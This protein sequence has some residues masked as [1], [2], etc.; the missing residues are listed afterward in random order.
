[1]SRIAGID[2]CGARWVCVTF[3]TDSRELGA[4]LLETRE[5][6]PARW[7]VAAIDVPIGLPETGPRAADHEARR[8]LRAPR[9]ASVFSCPPRAVLDS[10]TWEEMSER[11]RSI[12]GTGVSKQAFGILRKVREVDSLLRSSPEA[13]SCF[14]EAHPEVSFAAWA[15]HSMRHGKKSVA[16]KQERRELIDA[17]FGRTAFPQRQDELRDF[18]VPADDLAD[19]FA[20]LWTAER[21]S[22]GNA[23]S[24]PVDPEFD[25]TGLPMRIVY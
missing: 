2:G 23:R 3:D 5:L 7:S 11:S 16:G 12:S 6:L 1:M 17:Y 8:F 19:A 22:Q 21:Y 15:G 18:R 10:G 25:A 20:C 4:E 13:R 9:A 24:L 14:V